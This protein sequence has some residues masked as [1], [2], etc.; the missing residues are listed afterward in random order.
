MDQFIQAA[1][2]LFDSPFVLFLAVIVITAIIADCVYR[3]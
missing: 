1:I 3:S 2:A